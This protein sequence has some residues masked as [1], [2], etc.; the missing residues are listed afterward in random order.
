MTAP[1]L[2]YEVSA[3]MTGPGVSTGAIAGK[4]AEIVFDTS[5]TQSEELP[6]PADLL[7]TAFA[8]C[9]LKNVE[10]MS[11]FMPFSFSGASI[12]VVG[13]RGVN[14]PRIVL[15]NYVLRVKT[16]EP[17]RRLELLHHNIQTQG[18]I[19]NT[20]AVACS[21]RGELIAERLTGVSE[22]SLAA[23]PVS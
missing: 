6:G 23:T 8:A 21:V 5:A 3:R 10:R 9:V 20:L 13:E 11:S 17:L 4:R 16:D 15:I 22:R 1:L 12:V 19:Y 2:R 18:T 7:V 14:P